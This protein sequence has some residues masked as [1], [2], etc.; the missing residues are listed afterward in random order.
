MKRRTIYPSACSFRLVSGGCKIAV[1]LGVVLSGLAFGQV[2]TAGLKAHW[3]FDETSGLAAADASANKNN[4]VLNNFG[5]DNAQWIPGKVGGAISFNG[6]NYVE[7]ADHPS[8]GT[9]LTNGF[10]VST[11]FRSRVPLPATGGTRTPR[12]LEKG[13]GYFF[14]MNPGTGGMNLLVKKNNANF[15]ASLGDS[16]DANVWYHITGT[17]DGTTIRVYLN[18]DLKGSTALAAPMDDDHLPLRIGSD[19]AGA[20]F[21]GD[22]DE[23]MIY[24]HALTL[25]EIQQLAGKVVSGAPVITKQPQSQTV[26]EGTRVE[27]SVKADGKPPLAFEWRKNGQRLAGETNDTFVIAEAS[28]DQAGAYSVVV[29]NGDG[30][31]TSTAAN[32]A[33]TAIDL[34]LGLKAHWKM[35][36]TSGLIAADS[37]TNRNNGALNNFAGDTAQW[38]SG[39]VGRAIAFDGSNYIEVPDHPSIGADLTNGFTVSTWF[40][41]KVALPATGGTRTA[42]MLEKGDNYFFLMNPGT[43]G[44]NFLVKRN[45]ANFT[46]NLGDSL[47]ANV[48]YHIA[49]TFD[50]STARVYL[51]GELKGSVV[52]GGPSDDDQLPLRIGSDD[53][54][55]FFNGDMDEVQIWNRPLNPREL[56]NVMGRD[57]SEPPSVVRQPQPLTLFA[58]STATFSAVAQGKEPFRYLWYKGDQEIRSAT[59]PTLI[60]N[61]ISAPDAGSYRVKVSN[62]LG[63]SFSQSAT[64]TVIPVAGISTGQAANWKF[65]ETS[66]L[67][68]ADASGTGRTGQLVDFADTSSHWKAGQ[69]KGAL[70]FDGQASRVVVTNI[71]SLSLGQEATFAFWIK[72]ATYG[73]EFPGSNYTLNQ[74]QILRKGSLFDI[75]LV[76]DPG[77]VRRTIIANGVNAPQTIVELGV[78]QHFAIT[79]KNGLVRFYK[80]GFPLGDPKPAQ[81]GAPGTEAIVLGNRDATLDN[82]RLF[83][84]L[85]DEVAVWQRP[86]SETE[87]LEIAGKDVSGPPVIEVQP[88]STKKLEGTSITF[89]IVAT[90]KRPV[91]YQ[92]SRNGQPISGA[93]ANQLR[94]DNLKAADAAAYTVRVQ[95]DLGSVTSLP[96]QLTVETL[97]TITSGL[98]AYWNFDET[99]GTTLN[100]RSG[101]GLNG[102][103]QNFSAAP[104]VLGPIGGALDFDGVGAFVVVPHK[105]L[106]NLSEEGTLSAWINPRTFSVVG[107]YGRI[108]RKSVNYDLNIY[109]ANHALRIFGVDKLPFDAPANTVE[110]NTWQHVAVTIRNGSIQFYKNGKALGPAVAGRLGEVNRDDLII[111]NFQADLAINRLFNGL[112]DDLGIWARALSASDIEGIY[113]NG[114]AGKP[115]TATFEPLNIKSIQITNQV[116]ITF[117]T[118]Y[119]NRQHAVQRAGTLQT[120]TTGW[121]DEPN[122]QFTPVGTSLMRASFARPTSP[123]TFYRV[124][125]LPPPAIYQENFDSGAP[126]WTHGGAEDNWVLGSPAKGPMRAHSGASVYATGLTGTYRPFTDSY[127]R[128]PVI[129]LTGVSRA[130]LNFW[131]WR[132]TDVDPVFHGTVVNVLDADTLVVLQE[133]SRAAGTIPDWQQRNLKLGSSSLGKRII[134]E[135]RLYSDH[136][137]LREGWL[138]DDVAI[139]PE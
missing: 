31:A 56:R 97:D 80:N 110:L 88:I 44:M 7:V 79:Y 127:L 132:S 100:D 102:A 82:P 86:L 37:T 50:G 93:T 24:D 103:L 138:I 118:P 73:T 72:P 125:A 120:Q 22:M 58:G 91:S 16:L 11:W 62:S 117:F 28:P 115:L 4:G 21:N 98:V 129:N 101:N 12:M 122:V 48:W 123:F 19:D 90:G 113:Q 30:S 74:A 99:S 96:A 25:V 20:F 15:T 121:S 17:F 134:L 128:S 45:N 26:A 18:G 69:V 6:S 135:F 106:L 136:T 104:G 47:D 131:E 55:A 33:V 133:L 57:L 114:L 1:L 23:V 108:V 87:I 116:H 111:G 107:G 95:N 112:M 94:L 124:V 42:R 63:D 81:L 49:G 41:S 130:A 43:G 10:T 35:D 77:S 119:T 84:G 5:A 54:G 137:N 76:D 40:R 78:W 126:G 66:G 83:N 67:V 32:V 13:D 53:A 89:S 52:V 64:L 70:Q 65:D 38:I 34:K 109:E 85:M 14:L 8:I 51:N 139:L 29:S 3:K 36:E 92:W 68:A 2:P 60:L 27:L 105:D 39:Q 9:D 61:D 59:G 75:Y 71:A 46:A